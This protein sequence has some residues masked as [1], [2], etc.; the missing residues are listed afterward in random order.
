MQRLERRRAARSGFT[1]LEVLIVLAI[2][3]VIAAM[4][5]P[6]L[7]AQQ[8]NANIQV[9]K[10]SIKGL[11]SALEIYAVD[12]GASFPSGGQEI[13]D[14]LLVSSTAPDGRTLEPYLKAKP[15]DAWQRPLFY[16]YPANGKTTL[17]E[18]AI[19]SPGPDGK[20][21]NGGGDDINSWTTLPAATK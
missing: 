13:L 15:L 20:N 8:R 6:R 21:D 16:E 2:I 11:Q 14:S 4:V 18:P 7:V 12:H 17:D 3:G 9:T 10:Q 5:V 1:L 19:W